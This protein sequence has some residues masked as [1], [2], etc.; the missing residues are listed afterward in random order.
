MDSNRVSANA[1]DVYV[2]DERKGDTYGC[3]IGKADD[4]T[5][6]IGVCRRNDKVREATEDEEGRVWVLARM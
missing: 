3:N 1:I 2:G 4:G 5:V 6:A